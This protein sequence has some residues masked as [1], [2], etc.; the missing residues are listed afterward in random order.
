MPS[1]TVKE[2]LTFHAALRLAEKEEQAVRVEEVLT[3]LGLRQ[4]A[5]T[6]VGGDD[7]KGVSGGEKR[8]LSLGKCESHILHFTCS[9][10]TH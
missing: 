5:Q 4:C 1:L 7:L 8:R 2:T 3:T 10:F 6:R 9:V